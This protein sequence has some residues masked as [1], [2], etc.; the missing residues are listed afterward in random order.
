MTA[1]EGGLQ[2]VNPDAMPS[3]RPWRVAA[4][5]E[6]PIPFYVPHYRALASQPD[7]DL[8]VLFLSDAGLT[9]FAYHDVRIEYSDEILDG[10]RSH[11]LTRAGD[12]SRGMRGFM[13][14]IRSL[15]GLIARERYDAVWIHGY[16]LPG[17]WAAFAACISSGVPM[18]L[19]GESELMFGRGLAR[20]AAKTVAFR[21]LFPRISAFLYIG[22]LNRDFYL[23][24]G[25][26]TAKLFPMPYGIDNAWFEGEGEDERAVWRREIRTQLGIAEDVI[27]FV[28]HSKHRLP[29][30]PADVVRAFARLG[31]RPDAVLVLVGDG[32]QRSEIDAA[33]TELVEGQ[34]VFR[35]GFQ[36]YEE[37]RKILAAA[38]VLA[39]ASEENWGMA[40]NE[41]LAAGLAILCSDQVAGVVDMVE[42]G[43]NG[44][45]FRSRDAEDLARRMRELADDRALAERM[46]AESRRKAREFGFPA[47]NDGLRA[48]L[49]AV[50][51]A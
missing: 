13:N 43:V 42:D 12:G 31:P 20:R 47:M 26:P 2:A 37:L 44:H 49:A 9:P 11:V 19:R 1:A 16:N 8:E 25:V 51:P 21:L 38:D 32:D 5:I 22:T 30:R 48:A 28:N 15:R 36:P 6:R 17:H 4:V 18:M 46:R 40:V 27:V 39:F 50:T 24:Y 35:L 29:K 33:C 34:R 10:Y 45:V 7:I 23:S 41:G 14:L 3:R